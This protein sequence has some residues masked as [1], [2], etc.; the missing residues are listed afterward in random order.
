MY[1]LIC[2]VGL[3]FAFKAEKHKKKFDIQTYK[4][5][6]AF[7]EGKSLDEIEKVPKMVIEDC[8]IEDIKK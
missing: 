6:N 7:L 8:K 2:A 5:I 3:F 4:E 1:L